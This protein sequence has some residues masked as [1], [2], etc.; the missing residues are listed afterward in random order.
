MSSMCAPYKKKVYTHLS[1]SN[2]TQLHT[3]K[4]FYESL[5]Y[6]AGPYSNEFEH[7]WVISVIIK[8]ST[9]DVCSSFLRVL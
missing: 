7:Y 4:D 5:I 2:H 6:V 1:A 8:N 9:F 3:H